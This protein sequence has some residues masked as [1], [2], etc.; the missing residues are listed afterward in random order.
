LR[1]KY[2]K[3]ESNIMELKRLGATVLHGVDAKNDMHM[4]KYVHYVIMLFG[5]KSLIKVLYPGLR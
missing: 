1:G 4:I 5:C 3:A 2:S